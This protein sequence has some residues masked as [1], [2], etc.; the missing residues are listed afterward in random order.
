[1]KKAVTIVL[2]II[3]VVAIVAIGG[4]WVYNQFFADSAPVT[5]TNEMV[6]DDGGETILTEHILTEN[7]IVENYD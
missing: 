7:V 2:A 3:G 5:F 1:M 6:L 4:H